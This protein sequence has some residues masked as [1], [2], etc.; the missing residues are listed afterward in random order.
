VQSGGAELGATALN[1]AALFPLL[2]VEPPH[3][4]A[5]G[6]IVIKAPTVDLSA[7]SSPSI[8]TEDAPARKPSHTALNCTAHTESTSGTSRLNSSCDGGSGEKAVDRVGTHKN[9][10]Y[11]SI[12]AAPPLLSVATH[13]AAPRAG[14]GEALED[15]AERP[16]VVLRRAVEHVARERQRGREILRRLGLARACA[17]G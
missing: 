10:R 14:R 1:V 11:I 6:F 9:W 17:R 12:R 4:D 13:E 15:V 3:E 7:T 2:C 16:V 5:P 8:V